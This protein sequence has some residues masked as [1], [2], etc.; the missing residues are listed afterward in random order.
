MGWLDDSS[1]PILLCL[2]YHFTDMQ[3]KGKISTTQLKLLDSTG[4]TV[5]LPGNAISI[6]VN[7]PNQ[8]GILILKTKKV[9][10]CR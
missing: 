5:Q 4:G 7:L 2:S 10:Y 6:L 9:D 3:P 1:H 8:V